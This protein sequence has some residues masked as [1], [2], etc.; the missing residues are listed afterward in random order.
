VELDAAFW[1]TMHPDKAG[2]WSVTGPKGVRSLTCVYDNDGGHSMDMMP[3]LRGW[4]KYGIYL[5]AEQPYWSGDPVRRTWA[6]SAP[7]DFFGGVNKAPIFHISSGSSLATAAMTNEGDVDA[8]P[9]WSI[10][11]PTTSVTVGVGGRT[12]TAPI[13]IA[14]GSTLVIDSDPVKRSALLDGVNVYKQLSSWNFAPIPPGQ[15]MELSLSMAG[16]GS[17]M[18]EITPRYFRS[19]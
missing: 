18:A 16:T 10:T 4:E 19:W 12:V 3:T 5:A 1:H 17:V 7:V 6:Q 13:T 9:V 15:N 2:V 8:W 14:E 11:G